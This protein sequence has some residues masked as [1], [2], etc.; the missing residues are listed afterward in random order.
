ME[1]TLA[2]SG[3]GAMGAKAMVQRGAKQSA[4]V[5]K[6]DTESVTR[7]KKPA[8]SVSKKKSGSRKGST[9]RQGR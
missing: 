5:V 3:N 1:S 8:V 2:A 4:T 7:R 9:V 6:S